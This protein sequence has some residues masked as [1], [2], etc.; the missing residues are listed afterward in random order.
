MGLAQTVYGIS[1]YVYI[2]RINRIYT[3]FPYEPYIFPYIPYIFEIS[4]SE[5]IF[6]GVILY[7]LKSCIN[8]FNLVV[9]KNFKGSYACPKRPKHTDTHGHCHETPLLPPPHQ[10]TLFVYAHMCVCVCVCEEVHACTR[11]VRASVFA[12]VLGFVHVRVYLCVCVHVCV[13][14]RACMHTCACA[15]LHVRVHAYVCECVCMLM[16]A[17]ACACLRLREHACARACL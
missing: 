15:C 14:L 1:V 7:L 10:I 4:T 5:F 2:R 12:R 17:C 11:V 9:P 6:G 3:Y 13:H 16:C 8:L